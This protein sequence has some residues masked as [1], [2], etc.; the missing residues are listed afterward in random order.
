MLT[1]DYVFRLVLELL[2]FISL[3]HPFVSDS[4]NGMEPRRMGLLHVSKCSKPTKCLTLA[5]SLPTQP[6]VKLNIDG[7]SIGNPEN[8]GGVGLLETQVAKS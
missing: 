7:A 2:H 3:T 8:S 4:C 5:W 6:F 1:A